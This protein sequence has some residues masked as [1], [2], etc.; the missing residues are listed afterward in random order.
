MTVEHRAAALLPV[1]TRDGRASSSGGRVSGVALEF[2][3]LSHPLPWL[4]TFDSGA[5]RDQARAGFDVEALFVH[6]GQVACP[7]GSDI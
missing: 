6:G 3:G 7:A 2:G 5:F 4:E 1:V